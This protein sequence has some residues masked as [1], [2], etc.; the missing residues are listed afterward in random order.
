MTVGEKEG[1]QRARNR[2]RAG[3]GTRAL[4]CFGQGADLG[5]SG[6]AK[7]PQ[8]RKHC[9]GRGVE[10]PQRALRA[11]PIPHHRAASPPRRRRSPT[12]L[13]S[14]SPPLPPGTIAG[15]RPSPAASADGRLQYGLCGALFAGS[16]ARARAGEGARGSP[17]GTRGA[18]GPFEQRGLRPTLPRAAAAQLP[19]PANPGPPFP[20]L[21]NH[22]HPFNPGA[23]PAI[24]ARSV[25]ARLLSLAPLPPAPEAPLP[26]PLWDPAEPYPC[27]RSL[28]RR[29]SREGRAG[30]SRSGAGR[31]FSHGNGCRRGA[32]GPGPCNGGGGSRA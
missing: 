12:E 32:G 19:S 28:G 1:E 17:S 14:Q 5:Q 15:L 8:K 16:R 21:S 26:P 30:A 24:S 25:A 18:R 22:S 20:A 3:R 4:H 23:V 29:W 27:C 13:L 31:D 9:G 7:S 10:S 11:L 6:Q 2:R